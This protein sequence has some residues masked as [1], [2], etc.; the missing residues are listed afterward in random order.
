M[1]AEELAD[2]LHTT[3]IPL[4]IA[5]RRRVGRLLEAVASSF[6]FSANG[7][8]ETA[9]QAAAWSTVREE[10]RKD[11]AATTWEQAKGTIPA[12]DAAFAAAHPDHD[13]PAQETL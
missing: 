12:H 8:D 6:R 1:N 2:L 11:F 4:S 13:Y 10:F 5:D 7:M 3:D 9:V